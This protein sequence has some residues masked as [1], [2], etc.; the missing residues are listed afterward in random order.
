MWLTGD[1]DGPPLAIDWQD[2]D[3]IDSLARR[4]AT[5]VTL[6]GERAAVTG[7]GRLGRF[8]CGGRA[9]LL[10]ARDDWLALNLSRDDDRALLP[11]L[12]GSGRLT[13]RDFASSD[14]EG[15]WRLLRREAQG[16][17]A[18][19]LEERAAMLGVCL[20]V[21][22]GSSGPMSASGGPRPR[23]RSRR[24]VLVAD[25]SAM[26]A[27]P[28]CARL[29]QRRGATVVKIEDPVRPDGARRGSPRFYDLLNAEKLSVALGLRS[30]LGRHRLLELLHEADVIITS[31]RARAIDQLGISV[32]DVLSSASDKVWTAVTAYGWESNKVGFGDDAAAGAGLVAWH[33]SDGEPR[34]AADAIADPLCGIE[35]AALTMDCIERGGRWF[36]DASL[37]G[38]AAKAAPHGTA[39]RMAVLRD[40]R[41]FFDDEPVMPPRARIAAPSAPPL[42][43]HSEVLAE[44]Q[45]QVPEGGR[46]LFPFAVRPSAFT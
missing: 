22:A 20:S 39:A 4:F 28:L 33:P 32:D 17:D 42:G 45:S 23:A 18:R 31:C 13:A 3:R 29:L 34:F 21:V 9:H 38:A 1:E 8:S 46:G 24:E 7:L 43:R 30:E 2:S 19:E 44:L 41:W 16:H 11:A 14:G 27:G 6:V 25:L 15:L 26:W 5:D 37:A 12:F 40:G 35:A 10:R 36:V